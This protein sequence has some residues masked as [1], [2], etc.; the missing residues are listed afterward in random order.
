MPC[1]KHW[2]KIN[3]MNNSGNDVLFAMQQRNLV[4]NYNFLYYSNKV[5][6]SLITFNHPDGWVYRNLSKNGTIGFD[7]ASKSCLIQTGTDDSKMTFSQVISEFPRWQKQLCGRKISACAVIHN[8]EEAQVNFELTFSIHDGVSTSSKSIFFDPKE[9]KEICIELD[10]HQKATK[11]QL[12]LAC[13]T[14][15]AIILVEK[16][17]ANIGNIALEA[18]PCM[19]TG[20]IGTRKQYIATENPP[21]GELSLCMAAIELDSNYTRLDSVINNRFGVGIKGYSMLLD[22]RGYFS[23]AWDNG[24]KVD[25]DATTRTAPGTGTITGDHVSTFENDIFLEHNHGLDFSIDKSIGTGD[26]G[27][28]IIINTS[29]QSRTNI[30]ANG[31]ETRSKNIAEL[32]TIKWA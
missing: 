31:K 26:K 8:P 27:V 16:V 32:Y 24:A 10:I 21:E 13:S 20:I 11:V 7:D 22:M 2:Q 5:V 17:Y 3:S 28:A 1:Y 25:T 18:L 14:K 4:Y 29:G 19:I 9:Q 30:D 12:L 23:R 6:D 15:N